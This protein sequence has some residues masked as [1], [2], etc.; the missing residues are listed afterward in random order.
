MLF[1]SVNGAAW[2]QYAGN[3]CE[4]VW[5]ESESAARLYLEITLASGSVAY[6][7]AQ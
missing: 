7:L 1:R 4:A 2:G 6:R 3:V 5:E